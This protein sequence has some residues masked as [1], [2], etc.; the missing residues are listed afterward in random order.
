MKKNFI[1]KSGK[2]EF[3]ANIRDHG[4]NFGVFSRNAEKVI[5]EV[6]EKHTDDIPIFK[7]YLDPFENKTGD[8]WHVFVEGVGDRMFYGWRVDGKFDPENGHRFNINKLLVDPYAKAIAGKYSYE[9]ESI[10]GYN[11]NLTEAF[12][13]DLSFSKTDSAKFIN[14]GIIIAV[15]SIIK[16]LFFI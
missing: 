14:K 15:I 8:I 7:Y 5:L 3:G 11:K 9:D 16:P 13:D 6:F 12:G 2:P 4:T 1:V 10:Y